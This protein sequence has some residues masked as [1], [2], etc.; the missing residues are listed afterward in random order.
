[1]F[2]TRN[3]T[4]LGLH[5]SDFSMIFY[6]FYKILQNSIIIQDS[7]F[8]LSPWKF[9]K[10]HTYAH[11]WHLRPWKDQKCC[12]VA[13]GHGEAAGLPES[14]RFRRRSRPGR[15]WGRFRSSPRDDLRPETGRRQRQPGR[16]A[17]QGG[18]DR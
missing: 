14:R 15:R 4:K 18:G 17:A 6:A 11:A 1:V 8:Q 5:F 2:F 3:P 16:A 12:N 9:S 7:N 13:L 10:T